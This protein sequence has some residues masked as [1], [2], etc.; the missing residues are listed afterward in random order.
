MQIKAK[1]NTNLKIKNHSFLNMNYKK[2]L[3]SYGS[4]IEQLS[5]NKSLSINES[6]KRQVAYLDYLHAIVI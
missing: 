3:L 4:G 1:E 5:G 6:D 2:S